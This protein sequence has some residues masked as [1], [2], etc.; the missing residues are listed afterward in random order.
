MSLNIVTLTGRLTADPQS[1]KAGQYDLVEFSLAVDDGFGDKKKT[2]F[3]D[4]MAWGKT[5]EAMKQFTSK[6][7][8]VGVNGKLQQNRWE[9]DGKNFSKVVVVADKVEF[10]GG[11][12]DKAVRD[13]NLDGGQITFDSIPF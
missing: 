10:L 7:S 12:N 2:F 1:R 11:K 3:F 6:G 5:G 8:M 4:C 9:K 13:D